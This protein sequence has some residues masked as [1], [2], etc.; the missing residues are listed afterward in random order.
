[1]PLTDIETELRLRA[2]Q[3]IEAGTLPTT[4]PNR[5]WG[6]NGSGEPC[7]LCGKYIHPNDIEYKFEIGDV[8]PAT[9]RF[10]FMCHAAWQFES[11]RQI[12]LDERIE[13]KRSMTLSGASF[14]KSRY[15]KRGATK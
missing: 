1:M 15:V 2:R 3:L 6:G 10:H 12:R 13:A 8:D 4:I 9:Y 7:S 11:A 14:G 5:T